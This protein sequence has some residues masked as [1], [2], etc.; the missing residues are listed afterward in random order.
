MIDARITLT[1]SPHILWHSFLRSAVSFANKIM[2]CIT[3]YDVPEYLR[4]GELYASL[5]SEDVAPFQVPSN[6]TKR[7]IKLYNLDGLRHLL[8]SLRYWIV[9]DPPETVVE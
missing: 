7:E 4:T 9:I 1:W 3:R 6:A 2:I 5:C 8:E